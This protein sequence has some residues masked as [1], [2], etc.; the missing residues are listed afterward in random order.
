MIIILYFVL[1]TYYLF[2]FPF[3]ITYSIYR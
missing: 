1:S 3:C 2:T